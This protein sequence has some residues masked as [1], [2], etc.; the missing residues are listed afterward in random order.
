[1]KTLKFN[2]AECGVDFLINVLHCTELSKQHLISGS[3]N[4]DV[5]EV[6]VFKKGN[7]YLQLGDQKIKIRDHTVLFVSPFQI[8]EYYVNFKALDFNILIFQ[9]EFLNE[10][11][12]DKL[13]TYRLLYFY[14]YD[15]PTVLTSSA[16]QIQSINYIL[17]EIKSELIQPNMDSAHI[18]RS[19]IYYLLQRLNRSYAHQNG[20]PFQIDTSNH[21]YTFK[22][23]MEIHIKE[24]QRVQDYCEILGVSRVTLNTAVKNRFKCTATELLKQRLLTAIKNELIFSTKTISE[25]A[26]E[27]NYSEPHHLMRFFKSQT[28]ITPSEFSLT[29]QNGSI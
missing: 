25:I 16:V 21:A 17:T 18:I 6:L 26:Y 28:G 8:K 1:M 5:F 11:F 2:K 19:L 24:K 9:E 3:S 12:A 4:A 27:F 10:F 29:Y 22:K 7:G 14:Q 20:L 23:L 13:F 15:F